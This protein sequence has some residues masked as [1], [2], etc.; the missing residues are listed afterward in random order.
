M[1][2]L[3]TTLAATAISATAAIAMTGE[4][5]L[6]QDMMADMEAFGL[7]DAYTME[8][9]DALTVEE[10]ALI[11]LI[12]ANEEP[13]EVAEENNPALADRIETIIVN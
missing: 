7:A 1:K 5:Q 13:L 10:M 6:K 4:Q 11:Q 9:I 12:L 2:T 8:Q 3:M